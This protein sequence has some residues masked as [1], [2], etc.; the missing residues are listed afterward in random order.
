MFGCSR[1]QPVCQDK[2]R[3]TAFVLCF[4]AYTVWHPLPVSVI[5][6][7]RKPDPLDTMYYLGAKEIPC[8]ENPDDADSL[9]S[10]AAFTFVLRPTSVTP[11]N[12]VTPHKR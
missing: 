11:S 2:H 4:C 12:L 5:R 1:L 10:D 3:T 7:L 6:A 9:T 8:V